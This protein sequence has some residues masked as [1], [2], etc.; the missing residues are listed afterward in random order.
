MKALNAGPK[1]VVTAPPLDLKGW[2][3]DRAKRRIRFVEKYV[4]VRRV[5]VPASR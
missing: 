3:T 1:A 2:P 4:I 5:L